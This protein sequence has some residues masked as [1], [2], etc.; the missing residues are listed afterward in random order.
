MRRP[1]KTQVNKGRDGRKDI[2]VRARRWIIKGQA[3]LHEEVAR[4]DTRVP[5]RGGTDKA[6]GDSRNVLGRQTG[7]QVGG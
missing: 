4:Y 7:G 3:H 5:A 6:I 2:V 1:S